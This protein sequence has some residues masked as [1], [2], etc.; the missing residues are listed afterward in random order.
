[1]WPTCSAASVFVGVFTGAIV[2]G[3]AGVQRLEG[4]TAPG[5]RRCQ[6]PCGYGY[7]IIHT[8][9]HVELEMVIAQF[10]SQPDAQGSCLV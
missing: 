7:V 2:W 9:R 4:A 3:P 5:C 1:M 10:A 6:C 8:Y